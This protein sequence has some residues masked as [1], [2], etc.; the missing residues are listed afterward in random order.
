MPFTGAHPSLFLPFLRHR[1]LSA[2]GLIAGSISPDFEYFIKMS[3]GS[4]HSH[5]IAGIF[6]FDLPVSILIALIFH[7]VIK[8]PLSDHLP[9]V[10]KKRDILE[11]DFDFI[12]Y[13]KKNFFRLAGCI[14]I[15]V[16]SH[17]A[18]DGFTHN[19]WVI[20]QI[21]VYQMI[22]LRVGKL[23]YPLFYLLQQVSTT[24]GSLAMVIY[25]LILPVKSTQ[26]NAVKSKFKWFWTLTLTLTVA[27]FLL[28]FLLFDTWSESGKIKMPELGDAVVT[29][30]STF[31]IALTSAAYLAGK[32]GSRKTILTG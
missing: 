6:Y 10:L 16:T 28:R 8:R 30:I 25:V 20:R 15:G 32:S 29:L 19:T 5:T 13:L 9:E 31:L 18:W 12:P 1:R 17:L 2:T 7:Q 3:S 4:N 26:P 22:S 21:P 14:L 27:L 24:L 11:K 23:D